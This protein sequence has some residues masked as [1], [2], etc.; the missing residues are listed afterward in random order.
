MSELY[1]ESHQISPMKYCSKA[2]DA[3]ARIAFESGEWLAQEKIDGALYQLEKT[4]SGCVYLFSR[5]IS[6]KT[7][8]LAEKS[9]NFPHIK[10][11][12]YDNL[13]ADTVIIGEIY[14]VGGHSNDVTKLTGCLPQN[15]VNRQFKMSEYGGPAHYFIFD[16][17][18]W[19]GENLQD[20]GF[21]ERARYLNNFDETEYIQIA[22]IFDSNFEEELQKYLLVAEKEWYLKRKIVLIVRKCELQRNKLLSGKNTWIALILFVSILKIL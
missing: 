16:I 9:D 15:A 5:S 8:E 6:K 18:Y 21:E 12:A 1:P 20:K 22:K 19:N 17:I 2:S 7:G 11:W 4:K 10:Q 3:Q 14:V 13:P